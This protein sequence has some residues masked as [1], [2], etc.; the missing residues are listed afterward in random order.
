MFQDVAA[1]VS[2]VLGRWF[3]VLASGCLASRLAFRL[4]VFHRLDEFNASGFGRCVT[5]VTCV[6]LSHSASCSFHLDSD[7]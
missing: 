5:C 7:L 3:G 1:C 2:L 6:H 4:P